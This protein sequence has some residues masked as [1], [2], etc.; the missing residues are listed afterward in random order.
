MDVTVKI[1]AGKGGCK[2]QKV[3]VTAGGKTFTRIMSEEELLGEGEEISEAEIWYKAKTLIRQ[4]AK[5][6]EKD[7]AKEAVE[8]RVFKL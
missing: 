3:T 5:N 6:A 7:R 4:E 1:E 2:H 8:K